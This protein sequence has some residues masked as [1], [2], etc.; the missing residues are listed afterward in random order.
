MTTSAKRRLPSRLL[1]CVLCLLCFVMG[2]PAAAA[3]SGGIAW[4]QDELDFMAAHPEIRLGV[5]PTFVPYEFIDTDGV[6][7]GI[8]ADYIELISKAT[9]LTMTVAKGL[10]WA[11]A[12]EKAVGR[13]LDVLP[14][15]AQTTEREKYF[16]FPRGI[17]PSNGLFSLTKAPGR[18]NPL[19]I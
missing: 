4:S 14:C 16:L 19:T 12:Y 7:K 2:A 1:L 13:E 3:A 5:D 17:T 18:L 8:A 10:T 11:Q 9:G 15:V 6:Y